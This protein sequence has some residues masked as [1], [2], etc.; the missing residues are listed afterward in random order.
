MKIHTIQLNIESLLGG[1]NHMD[2]TEFGA[3]LSLLVACYQSDNNLPSDDKRLSRMARV[4]PKVWQRIK[5]VVSPKFIQNDSSWSH[6]RVQKEID[7]YKLLS[8]KNRVNSLK[9][10]DTNQPVGSVSLTQIEANTSNNHQV[11][12]NKNKEYKTSALRLPC[13][14]DVSENIW[15]DHLKNRRAKKQPIT[16]TAL[17]GMRREADKLGWTLEQALTEACNRG[18]A[19]FK[20]EWMT[21]QTKEKESGKQKLAR[22]TRELL[23]SVRS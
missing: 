1:C 17:D 5:S 20:S 19:S 22:E 12:S 18:W 9:K 16:Q 10:R 7:K 11:T 13:P 14:D 3:Y 23:E 2:A 15:Q 8:T 21:N 4:S 6:V